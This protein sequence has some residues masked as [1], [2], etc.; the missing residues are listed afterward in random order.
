MIIIKNRN[1][2]TPW[3]VGHK[4]LN[5]GTTPWNYYIFLQN[6]QEAGASS[7]WNDTAPTSTH[8]TLGNY[9]GVNGTDDFLALLFASVDGIS[10]VG[11]YTGTGS[12]QTITLGFQPRFLMM[13]P[14]GSTSYG[15]YIV[16]TVRGWASDNDSYLMLNSQSNA[17]SAGFGQ[18]TSTGWSIDVTDDYI[19]GNNL[20]YIYYAHA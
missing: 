13:K 2:A 9:G 16:D 19:N 6:S 8:F 4:G 12:S 18:P 7:I 17:G 5:G 20:K 14:T 11:Y 15:W 10:K 1:S 3:V